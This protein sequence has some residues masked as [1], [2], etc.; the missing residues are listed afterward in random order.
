M[1]NIGGPAAIRTR[2]TGS[3]N[4]C[5]IQATLWGLEALHLCFGYKRDGFRNIFKCKVSLI[6][7]YSQIHGGK[8]S[9]S[10][11]LSDVGHC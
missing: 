10:C 11:R 8:T 7:V 1:V 5:D 2:V 9:T 6:P 4:Q 3:A